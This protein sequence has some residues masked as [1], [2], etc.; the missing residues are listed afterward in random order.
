M[1]PLL[2]WALLLAATPSPAADERALQPVLLV[3]GHY[4]RSIDVD[5][6]TRVWALC[7]EQLRQVELRVRPLGR[8]GDDVHVSAPCDATFLVSGVEGLEA[9]TVA[10]ARMKRK[11]ASVRTSPFGPAAVQLF[12]GREK[13]SVHRVRVGSSGYRLELRSS[14]GGAPTI[15]YDAQ[16]TDEA[17]WSLL[18][19]GDLDRDGAID[20]LVQAS[21][22]FDRREVRLFLSRPAQLDASGDRVE[23]VALTTPAVERAQPRTAK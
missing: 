19:A 20:L 23:E 22:A 2:S 16:S 17:E 12:L 9:G 1:H 3:P 11:P 15:L 21:D 18:W 6:G 14:G 10:T 13:A 5:H 7:G 8:A 4:E